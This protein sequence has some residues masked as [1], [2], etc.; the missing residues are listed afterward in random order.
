V[1]LHRGAMLPVLE[2]FEAKCQQRESD[3]R[4]KDE[5]EEPFTECHRWVGDGR[6]VRGIVRRCCAP[7]R[8]Q[9]E[10]GGE[11]QTHQAGNL[12]HT[13]ILRDKSIRLF[14]PVQGHSSQSTLASERTTAR[15]FRKSTAR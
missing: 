8:L 13:D 6:Q 5:P 3:C 12:S 11:Y 9:Q 10:G 4:R 1:E 15:S 14:D 7:E 2:Q